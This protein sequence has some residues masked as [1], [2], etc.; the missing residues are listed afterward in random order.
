MITREELRGLVDKLPDSELGTA[1][2]FLEYLRYTADPVLRAFLDA[3]EDDEPETEEER[4]AVLKAREEFK[5]GHVVPLEEVK[6]E[7]GL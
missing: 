3:P 4:A 5:A 6:H 7:F 2:R 1:R